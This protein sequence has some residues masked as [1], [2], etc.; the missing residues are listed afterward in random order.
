MGWLLGILLLFV[1]F[2]CWVLNW[3]G[4]P[5]NWCVLGAA[6]LYAWLGPTDSTVEL[7][8]PA[9]AGLT[10]LALLGEFGEFA[11]GAMGA[12]KAGGSKR[13]AALA[14]VGSMVGGIAGMC[15]SVPVPVPVVA[16]LV[17]AFL[18]G[19]LGAMIG[20]I[21]GELWKGRDFDASVEVGKSAFWGRMIGIVIKAIAGLA[22]LLLTLLCL[23]FF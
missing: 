9:L 4:L 3:L 22:M 17:G 6:G 19:G 21:L 11:A 8:W 13:A 15:V 18:F 12:H 20:A 14:I 5:G 23:F 2:A 10:V 16:Q 7:G 1:Q